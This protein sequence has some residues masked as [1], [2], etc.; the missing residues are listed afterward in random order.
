[1]TKGIATMNACVN[2]ADHAVLRRFILSIFLPIVLAA[3]LLASAI[4]TATVFVFD[5]MLVVFIAAAA[6]AVVVLL[7]R[8]YLTFCEL[9][10]AQARA[11]ESEKLKEALATL[12]TA[13][14]T[15]P[16]SVA[17]Y[18]KRQK[19]VIANRQYV[20]LY[21]L[22]DGEII[23]G[24]TMREILEMSAKRGVYLGEDP[25][26]YIAER[27]RAMEAPAD[28]RVIERFPD[29]R[30]ISKTRNLMPDGGWLSVHEDITDRQRAE[31]KIAYLARNDVLTGLFN[32][33]VLHERTERA[34]A[35]MRRSGR[36]C[37][38]FLIDLDDFK[39]VNDNFGHQVGDRLLQAVAGRLHAAVREVD[40]VARIGGDEFAIL[41]DCGDGARDSADRLAQ[42]ILE[43]LQEP[44]EIDGFI[45]HAYASIGVAIAPEDGADSPVL[46]RHADLAL[47]QA[48]EAGRGCVR[49]F[50]PEMDSALRVERAL[51]FDLRQAL[52]A[53]EFELH[54][55]AVVNVKTLQTVSAEALVRWRHPQHG[56]IPPDRFIKIAEKTGL[57][58]QL[59]EW[60]LNTAC[61]EAMRWP[62]NT[63]VAVNLS[64]TQ[65]KNGQVVEIVRN[66]L[67]TTQFPANRLTLEIT[68]STLLEHTDENL[69]VLEQLR[70]LGVRIALD[71]FGTGYSSL[72]YLR[73]IPFDVVK[74]DRSFV[75]AMAT[76]SRSESIV[77]AVVALSRSLNF[78]TVAE[79][80]ETQ[81]Q[82]ELIR[83][84]GCTTVQGY[85]FARP[86]PASELD[87]ST[88]CGGAMNR[89]A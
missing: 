22:K 33:T 34:L 58:N 24:M 21:K 37:A 53:E 84:A 42:R 77:A 51:E 57:I 81:E 87:F 31:D 62:S 46:Q 69:M 89:A 65:F 41:L 68:E 66:A 3:M 1:M 64:P 16:Q 60:V 79:G 56:M 47:Y 36:E 80:I 76:S 7:R 10:F 2:T 72:S 30:V 23:P 32:R 27:V 18:D 43:S 83:A 67:V 17:L 52:M 63:S 59:G 45:I 39:V 19:I 49:F 48:K 4:I 78:T 25:E 85:L 11:M 29:G 74:I 50:N 12:D 70:A 73:T 44:V 8:A 38:I 28:E 71:D 88:H 86:K 35:H 54:Y 75:V 26:K 82:F 20:A 5:S 61:A 9:V 13:L 40:T 55:Q 6:L 14:N 15:M